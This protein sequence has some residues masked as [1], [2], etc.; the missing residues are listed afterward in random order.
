MLSIMLLNSSK[1]NPKIEDS[2]EVIKTLKEDNY[3]P[4]VAVDQGLYYNTIV[5]P[6]R[7]IIFLEKN[8]DTDPARQFDNKGLKTDPNNPDNIL[9]KY[10]YSDMYDLIERGINWDDKQFVREY[11]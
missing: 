3:A 10:M 6:D 7:R 9:I 8:E 5:Y 11:K 4:S 2:K 1:V